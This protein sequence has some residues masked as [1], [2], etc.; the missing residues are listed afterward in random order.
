MSLDLICGVIIGFVI[1]FFVLKRTI[2]RTG[3]GQ[4]KMCRDTCPYYRTAVNDVVK[5]EV[6]DDV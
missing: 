2:N 4:L 3:Y 5:T 1:S 6:T